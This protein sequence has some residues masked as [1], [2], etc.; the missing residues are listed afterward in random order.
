MSFVCLAGTYIPRKEEEVVET[1]LASVVLPNQALKLRAR[2]ETKVCIS[3]SGVSV[4]PV[5]SIC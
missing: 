1:I 3:V 4:G 2:K 5:F